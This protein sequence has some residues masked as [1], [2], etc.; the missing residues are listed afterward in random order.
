MGARR[1]GAVFCGGSFQRWTVAA[2]CGAL[3]IAIPYVPTSKRS[4]FTELPDG[5]RYFQGGTHEDDMAAQVIRK[6]SLEESS[7][8][9]HVVDQNGVQ[10][11]SALHRNCSVV[12][13]DSSMRRSKFGPRIDAADAVYRMNFAPLKDFAADV[14]LRT[15]TQ[16][17]NPEKL[18]LLVRENVE[19]QM[20]TG[21]KPR[22]TVVGD[23][24]GS[25]PVTGSKGPCIEYS[26]GGTCVRRV[27]N[28]RPTVMDKQVQ[29]VAEQLLETLQDGLDG[30][31]VPS[32]GLY[33]LCL[34]LMECSHVDVFGMGVGTIN[35]KD[36]S[37]LE[38]FKDPHFHGWDARHDVEMERA[39]MRILSSGY[40]TSP[41]TAGFG[42]MQ[43]HNPLKGVKPG[44][45][46]DLTADSPCTSG[47]HC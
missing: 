22:V 39:L 19:F 14:G 7:K 31:A 47:I 24:T 23:A 41:L 25:D 9:Q 38:Y 43:W 33:C 37:D 6:S 42:S 17:V 13:N 16:C 8:A 45:N 32:T 11:S 34:A 30:D 26:P 36:L 18:R 44:A 35:H 20:D 21:E 12:G 2:I 4:C 28:S 15:Y 5:R 40:W 3:C 29:Q 46:E 27:V 1:S 10:A